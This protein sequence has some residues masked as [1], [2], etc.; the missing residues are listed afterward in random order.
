MNVYYIIETRISIMLIRVFLILNIILLFFNAFVFKLGNG[1]FYITN[2]FLIIF[3]F[4]F[5]IR[6]PRKFL[7]KIIILYKKTPLKHLINF[8]IWLYVSGFILFIIG[9]ADILIM[10]YITVKLM[11]PFLFGY[12]LSAFFIPKYISYDNLIKVLFGLFFFIFIVGILG[13]IGDLYSIQFLQAIPN[14]LSNLKN[15]SQ[16]VEMMQDAVSGLPRARSLFHEPGTFAF[17]IF[18]YIPIIYSVCLG[19]FS[20]YKNKIINFIIKRSLI[21][22]ALTNLILTMSPINLIFVSL[23]TLAYFFK[24][25]F[26]IIVKKSI[27]VLFISFL[28]LLFLLIIF[29]VHT[30]AFTKMIVNSFIGRIINVLSSHSIDDLINNEGSLASRIVCYINSYILFLKS[31]LIGYGYDNARFYLYDQFINS[32]VPLTKE[33]MMNVEASVITGTG[34]AYNKSL[35]SGLLV[36]TGIIGTFLYYKF[37]FSNLSYIKR[38]SPY[39]HGNIKLFLK[40]I[41]WLCL[42]LLCTSFYTMDIPK[43]YIAFAYGLIASFTLFYYKKSIRTMGGK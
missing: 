19:K 3:Y 5:I 24:K 14:T 12:L 32:P 7:L 25:I 15:V 26:T 43:P 37:L 9:K 30:E 40:G 13:F 36:D 23:L 11:L 39:Y 38:I 22:L 35:L 1:F 20:I 4:Y 18:L 16:E 6:H 17:F 29:N 10:Y 33:M 34:V 21:P 42:A 27:V 28:L 31:P 2:I 41:K 8:F